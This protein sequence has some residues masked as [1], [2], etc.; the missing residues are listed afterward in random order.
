M[1]VLS[2]W[3]IPDW[4]LIMGKLIPRS[5]AA[6]KTV[7]K[8]YVPITTWFSVSHWA[9]QSYLLTCGHLRECD[10]MRNSTWHDGPVISI[11]WDPVGCYAVLP[12][13]GVKKH[14][15]WCVIIHHD[16]WLVDSCLKYFIRPLLPSSSQGCCYRLSTVLW[17]V[18]NVIRYLCKA[19]KIASLLFL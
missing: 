12:G 6:H 16:V 5:G 7:F 18:F 17:D 15:E 9:C 19:R 2:Y 1:G 11:T 4:S 14:L 8:L 3:I 13:F 10:K